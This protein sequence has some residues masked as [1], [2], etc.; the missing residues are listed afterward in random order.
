M[1][2]TITIKYQ[3]VDQDLKD[4]PEAL[5]DALHKTAIDRISEM[6]QAGYTS[7]ELSYHDHRWSDNQYS[8]NWTATKTFAEEEKEPTPYEKMVILAQN[9]IT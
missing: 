2:T 4:P 5:H 9:N 3:W 6:M 1:T 7:G 8:G